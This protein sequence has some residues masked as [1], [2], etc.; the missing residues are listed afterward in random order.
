M[1][2][3][4]VGQS[5]LRIGFALIQTRI[6]ISQYGFVIASAEMIVM[7]MLRGRSED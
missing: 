1:R 2:R 6:A 3:S 4:A 5:L 7:A